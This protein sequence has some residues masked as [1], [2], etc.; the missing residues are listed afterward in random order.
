MDLVKEYRSS[1]Y[2]FSKFYNFYP[3]SFILGA[4]TSC[5]FNGKRCHLELLLPTFFL[6]ITIQVQVQVL[7]TLTT[8]TPNNSQRS[9]KASLIPITTCSLSGPGRA[10]IFQPPA[11]TPWV[12]L[13]CL[14]ASASLSKPP[15]LAP[16]PSRLPHK[17]LQG[18]QACLFTVAHGHKIWLCSHHCPDLECPHFSWSVF[19][20]LG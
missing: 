14:R 6:W 16:T 2:N 18:N 5:L 11:Q 13:C 17:H 15:S 8:L 7:T 12:A 9:L 3:I 20:E 1:F 4:P 19:P 10:A